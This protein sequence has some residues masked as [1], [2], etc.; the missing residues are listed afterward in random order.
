VL[1]AKSNHKYLSCTAHELSTNFLT[2]FS[3]SS[4]NEKFR[5]KRNIDI[6]QEA[7]KRKQG[8]GRERIEG[9]NGSQRT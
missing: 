3:S 1:L 5:G 8:A 7:S 9:G 2:G 4:L 6:K